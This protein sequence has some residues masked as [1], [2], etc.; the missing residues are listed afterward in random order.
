MQLD[1]ATLSL[2]EGPMHRTWATIGSDVEALGPATN[3]IAIEM[4]L[5]AG[6]LS[7][8]GSVEADRVLQ[9]LYKEHGYDR[10]TKFLEQ[11]VKLVW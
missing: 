4:V 1:Q 11:N 6:R 7:M 8:Y 9:G 10:V 2:I 5:D 3:D